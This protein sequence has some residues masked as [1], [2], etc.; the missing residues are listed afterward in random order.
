MNIHTRHD[1]EANG[2]ID[3]IDVYDEAQ[4]IYLSS[5]DVDSLGRSYADG[6][7]KDSADFHLSPWFSYNGDVYLESFQEFLRFDGSFGIEQNCFPSY[8][9]LSRMDTLIDPDNVLIPVPDSIR[10]PENEHLLASLMYSPED[11]KFYPA[12]FSKAEREEDM[13]VLSSKGFLSYNRGSETFKISDT[14]YDLTNPYLSLSGRNCL[15]EGMGPITYDM[16]LPHVILDMYGRARHYIISDS[17]K[18]DLVVGLD[19]FFDQNLLQ[20]FSRSI[21]TS[22]LPGIDGFD[23]KFINFM[24]ERVSS[25]D[26]DKIIS[27]LNSFGTIKRLP[28]ALA[29]T[30]LFSQLELIWNPSTSSFVYMGDIG[31]FSVGN[32]VVSRKVPGYVEIERKPTGFG[33]IY[34][35][36]E[37]P[38]DQWYYFSYRNNIMQ[39]VSSNEAYNNEILSMKEDRRVKNSKD[40]AFPYEYIIS[41]RRKMIDFKRRIEEIYGVNPQ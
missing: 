5:I 25:S 14:T 7:I 28:V 8:S 12:F 20:V 36:F 26:A 21:T 19:F 32:E 6:V 33:E 11:V 10:G 17:T 23:A 4:A 9:Y 24:K 31:V 30:M 35:Y 2:T 15:L 3:Y 22:N 38:G 13:K 37:M 34:L 27:D 41:T 16:L 18:F 29:Y 1:Y 39:T 40:E